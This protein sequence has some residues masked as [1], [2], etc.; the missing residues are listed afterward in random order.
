MFEPNETLTEY[1]DALFLVCKPLNRGDFLTH[2]AVTKIVG[3]Q[4]HK[5]HYQYCVVRLK[6]RMEAEREISLWPEVGIGY[7]LLTKQE[8]LT[9]LPQARM[10]RAKRQI[11]RAQI[12][13]AAISDRHL[14][15][16]ERRYRAAK[17]ESLAA[18]QRTLIIQ[19]RRLA[20]LSKEIEPRPR[21]QAAAM[22]PEVQPG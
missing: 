17:A 10:R 6:R 4:P 13:I 11:R 7:R 14:T 21:P 9:M 8:Q 18:S 20:A 15:V 19:S 1:V 16:H 3:V 12:S 5:E 22:R 2:E